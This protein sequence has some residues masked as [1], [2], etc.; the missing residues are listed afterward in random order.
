MSIPRA[1]VRL[2]F[3][4]DFTLIDAVDVV[5]YYADLGISHF[6]AS[7]LQRARSASTHGYDV[8]DYTTIDPALGGIEALRR[9]IA[10]L[11]TRDMGLILDVVPNHMAAHEENPWWFDVLEH[12]PQSRYASHFDITWENGA[13]ELQGKVLLPFLGRPVR[14]A[15][16][17]MR[18]VYR[19]HD[20][21]LLLAL[22]QRRYPLAPETYALVL[23]SDAATREPGTTHPQ[24]QRGSRQIGPASLSIDPAEIERRVARFNDDAGADR[25]RLPA[26][27]EAQHWRLAWWR[28]AAS[29]INWR[30][31]FDI[32]EL[33]ALR[34]DRAEVFA[35][36]H[37]PVFALYTEGLIDGV[38]I[39]HIDGIADP[40]IYCDRLRTG[41]IR[42]AG[43]RG[44]DGVDERA[45]IVVEKILAH[46]EDLR[47]DW[48][49]DGTTGYDFMD[50]SSALLHD[51]DGADELSA[52]WHA[53]GADDDFRDCERA[54]RGEIA[55]TLLAADVDRLL[56]A[57]HDARGGDP[58]AQPIEYATTRAAA[59]DILKAFD[60]YRT[61]CEPGRIGEFDRVILER[62]AAR[63]TGGASDA[64]VAAIGEL[65]AN[66]LAAATDSSGNAGGARLLRAFQ[67]LTPPIAAKAVED[68][69][70]YRYGRLLSRNE[71]GS[72]PAQ[73]AIDR[74]AFHS[75]CRSRLARNPAALLATATHD[76]KR[77][78]DSRARLAV[79]SE[80]AGA[81]AEMVHAWQVGNADLRASVDGSAAPEARDELMLLQTL[82]GAW[83]FEFDI[84][85]SPVR[86]AFLARIAE[87]QVKALREAKRM[88]SWTEPNRAYEGACA[89][90][91]RR[92]LEPDRP[93]LRPLVGFVER[94]ACAG[95]VNSLSQTLLRLTTP[96][97]PDL[98]QGCETWDLSLVD[99]DNRR[100]VDYAVRRPIDAGS[101][102]TALM[103]TWPSGRIKQALIAKILA[104]RARHTTL[105]RNGDYRALPVEG[106]LARHVIA[107][108]R[109]HQG[110]TAI[111]IATRF[112]A[113]HIDIVPRIVPLLWKDTAVKTGIER[114]ACHDLLSG[115]TVSAAQGALA[116]RDVLDVMPVAV[117]LPA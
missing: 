85:D 23:D 70:F 48:N 103:K 4:R 98:Y 11:R 32:N 93:A 74:D 110:Q 36:M 12:G 37:A 44:A 5:D 24:R 47:A 87:W 6:Y 97:I 20:N 67:Q 9:L 94:I 109:E 16:A 41:F 51:G 55:R 59:I 57:W 8:V 88:T 15:L 84:D 62:A 1:T 35:T 78:E 22:D 13:A 46:G 82:V 2:Q 81:W 83:P 73:L 92:S 102:P 34:V 19:T 108:S 58:D 80:L 71:V 112:A 14:D 45:Y 26:L 54:A 53:T 18:I 111:V 3:N 95:V 38:R 17:D 90:Y 60:V 28:D 42:A 117:L 105:W 104:H 75:A 115:R 30:R 40:R 113:R 27:L 65:I 69:A 79:L 86:N 33:V 106:N 29:R 64:T 91:L 96:G 25:E 68:T 50:Q 116:M 31:F 39:D 52:V 66:L 76:Q 56:G 61:Y 100:P 10:R 49:V 7:P 101:D 77:G 114:S 72:D 43:Q 63:A 107:F 21:R 99:P 89:Q